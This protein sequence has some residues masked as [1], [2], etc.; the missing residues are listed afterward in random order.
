V[1]PP[2]EHDGELRYIFPYIPVKAKKAS[3]AGK[4]APGARVLTSD[5]F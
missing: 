4:H 3:A 2:P 5:E 1:V